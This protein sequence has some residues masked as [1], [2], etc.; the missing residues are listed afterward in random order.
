MNDVD[1]VVRFHW[2]DWTVVI[3]Y[4][5]ALVM[6]G[7]WQARREKTAQEYFLAGRGMK[8]LPVGL[9]LM[10]AMTSAGDYLGGP[11]AMIQ[12][13]FLVLAG[14][15][16]WIV[17]Y[18]YVFYIILPFYRRLGVV[19]VYEYL[20][21]RFDSRVRTLAASIYVVW[22]ALML[23]IALYVPCLAMVAATNRDELLLPLV[24]VLGTVAT[25]Y[26]ALGGLS[27]VI[28][29]GVLQ[30]LVLFV[31]LGVQVVILLLNVEGGLSGV[32]EKAGSV[33]I[34]N[35]PYPET[36]SVV[37]SVFAYF[38]IPYTVFGMFWQTVV[39]RLNVFT[40]N[41]QVIQRF[42]S[43][44]SVKSARRSFFMM[45]VGDSL[46]SL[47]F[48]LM[49]IAYFAFYAKNGTLPDALAQN[50][51]KV[52]PWF[53][54]DMF[55]IGLTGL[56]IAAL[57]AVGIA[58]YSGM[59]NSVATVGMVDFVNRVFPSI[60]P[61]GEEDRPRQ[62]LQVR[63]SRILTLCFGLVAM[64]IAANAQSL[65]KLID[66]SMRLM[67]SFVGPILGIFLLGIFVRRAT[68]SGVFW[69]GIIGSF[70]GFYIMIWT[71][72]GL[73]RT[74]G[75]LHAMAFLFPDPER[76]ATLSPQ[77]I[78]TLGLLGM[79]IPAMVI[80]WWSKPDTHGGDLTWSALRKRPET[81]VTA[82]M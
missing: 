77:W 76:H 62:R 54:A 61:D 42:E 18:P 68:S 5:V 67:G 7:L 71:S 13:G 45:V 24:L 58:G 78:G 41:Q 80:S 25:V 43:A 59:L 46:S 10:A 44:D 69:G 2:L 12:Y 48:A 16:S 65:G 38:V 81:G 79:I 14:V 6:I 21:K 27:S 19:T 39:G 26:T 49:G 57:W 1:K 50:P 33:G 15:L 63:L 37:E 75:I 9:S 64:T 4:L 47:V 31:A 73:Y 22:Q 36:S 82:P 34:Y 60:V 66:I 52:V 30:S 3:A 32:L 11:S 51:D 8:W 23:G 53:V 29:G 72:P 35:K 20:E 70:I 55:P 40:C 74:G 17:L 28:W 56:I